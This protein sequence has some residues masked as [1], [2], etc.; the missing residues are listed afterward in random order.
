MKGL[1]DKLENY[2]AKCVNW[3]RTRAP[4]DAPLLGP[5]IDLDLEWTWTLN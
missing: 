4:F 2:K 3:T 5:W 1:A